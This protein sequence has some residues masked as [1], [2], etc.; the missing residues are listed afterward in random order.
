ME[1]TADY[2]TKYH[3][4]AQYPDS[5]RQAFYGSRASL[6]ATHHHRSS[7]AAGHLLH[8]LSVAAP[9]V[10]AETI[11]DPDKRWRAMRGVAVGSALLAETLWTL[12]LSQDRKKESE[13]RRALEDC[14]GR[15]L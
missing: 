8:I 1:R 11:K 14:E 4:K 15:C 6:G 3:P 2:R 10:I 5:T 13:A 9:L 7:G 12:R